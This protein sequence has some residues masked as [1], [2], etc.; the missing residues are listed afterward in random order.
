MYMNNNP[1]G[2]LPQFGGMG[3]MPQQQGMGQM[4]P[5]HPKMAGPGGF[6]GGQMTPPIMQGMPQQPTGMFPPTGMPGD[7]NAHGM[8]GGMMSRFGG[9]F[10]QRL[11]GMMQMPQ[12][13]GGGFPFMNR[14]NG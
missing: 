12:F 5:Q 7:P 6:N 14:H 1:L 2:S 10:M 8:F 11:S 4:Q 13:M 9:D 3:Q